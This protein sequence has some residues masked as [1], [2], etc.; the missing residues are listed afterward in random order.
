MT[1]AAPLQNRPHTDVYHISPALTAAVG[2]YEPV[3]GENKL[4]YAIILSFHASGDNLKSTAQ[5]NGIIPSADVRL[6]ETEVYTGQ[7]GLLQPY[8]TNIGWCWRLCGASTVSIIDL[9]R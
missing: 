3:M 7:I 2:R 8:W 6:G 5:N 4:S 9:M 1:A